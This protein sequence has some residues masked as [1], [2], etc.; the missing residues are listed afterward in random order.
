MHMHLFLLHIE[1]HAITAFYTFFFAGTA[2]Y[3]VTLCP[4]TP[5]VGPDTLD[6]E[7]LV[8]IIFVLWVP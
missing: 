1:E 8:H 6:M 2:F 3:T 5:A 7:L 4:D